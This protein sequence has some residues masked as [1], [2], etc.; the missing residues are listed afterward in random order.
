MSN[1]LTKRA[2]ISTA[3]SVHLPSANAPSAAAFLPLHDDGVTSSPPNA[4]VIRLMELLPEYYTDNLEM[5]AITAAE[6][7]ELDALWAAI[8]R[9]LAN[10]F[11][12][13]ADV[14]R[15]RDWERLL[16]IRPDTASQTLEQRR[17]VVLLRLQMRSLK[18][19][20]WLRSF[21]ARRFGEQNY[22]LEIIHNDYTMNLTV[23]HDDVVILDELVKILRHM[24]PITLL[25]HPTALLRLS[26]APARVGFGVALSTT[27]HYTITQNPDIKIAT[28]AKIS[29]AG[30]VVKV[31][32]YRI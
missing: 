7:P 19:L 20:R 6:K 2:I 31:I 25:F 5:L 30:S 9:L 12:K 18:T 32:E 23:S 13:T 4:P 11:I 10:Q 8:A 15:V 28:K 21:L 17:E 16:R 26:I 29:A 14:R 1:G 3:S 27:K 24:I 22:D